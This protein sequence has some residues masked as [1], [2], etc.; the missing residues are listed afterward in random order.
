MC[1]FLYYFNSATILKACSVCI[2]QLSRRVDKCTVL[3]HVGVFGCI[4]YER[5]SI[6][7]ENHF[8]Q[9]LVSGPNF[10]FGYFNT[11]YFFRFTIESIVQK[12]WEGK[13][14]DNFCCMTVLCSAII[15]TID[16]S[17]WRWTWSL[18]RYFHTYLD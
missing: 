14:R 18:L 15:S 10:G 8:I 12:A 16:N 7:F 17:C 1:L 13:L 2:S 4:S 5:Q 11:D 6:L 9:S 3:E